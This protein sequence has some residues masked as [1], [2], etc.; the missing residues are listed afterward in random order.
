MGKLCEVGLAELERVF[1]EGGFSEVEYRRARHVVGE[2]ERVKRAVQKLEEGKIF[3]EL[4]WESHES[5][6]VDFENSCEE[7]DSLVAMGREDAR[8]LG[9]RLSGGGFGGVTIHLVRREV[10][11]AYAG[12][13]ERAFV[14]GSGDGARV[15]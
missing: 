1:E 14:C 5:S 7:L 8:C 4:L 2:N 15:I 12:R 6:R 10:A 11:E 9:A 3:G 13:F